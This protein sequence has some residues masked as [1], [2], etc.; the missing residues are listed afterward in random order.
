MN[1]T[2]QIEQSEP[3]TAQQSLTALAGRGAF[4][5]VLMGLAN[6]VP[7]ISGG[8]MLLAAGIYPRFINAIAEVTT[9]KFRMRS[10]VV[11]ASVVIAALLGIILLAGVLK[12]LVVDYRWIMYSLFIGLTLGGLPVVYRMAKPIN[13]QVITTAIVAFLGMAGLAYLQATGVVGSTGSSSMMLGIA[14]VSGAAAMILPGLSGGYI[15][16]LLGQYVPI[17]SGISEFKD[18]LKAGDLNAAMDPAMNVMLPVGIG[19]ILGVV[20]ISNLLKW[21]LKN[22]RQA[23]LGLLIGLLLG[24]VAGLWPFQ[25]SVE[26]VVGETVIKGQLVTAENLEEFERE[27]FPTEFFRPTG[28][29][30]WSAIALGFIGFSITTIVARIGGDDSEV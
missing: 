23:T 4:G 20:V 26:P 29:Q 5:G 28:S 27:D 11:L 1:E 2:S 14:G 24:S 19:V 22:Y 9:F 13:S 6:L 16:L 25:H 30:V 8:T 12:D 17:L 18:A 7:G 3:T 21:L 10:L 15:L